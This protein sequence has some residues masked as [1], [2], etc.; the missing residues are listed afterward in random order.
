M[1]IKLLNSTSVAFQLQ[2]VIYEDEKTLNRTEDEYNF[3]S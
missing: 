3:A 2:F 1:L